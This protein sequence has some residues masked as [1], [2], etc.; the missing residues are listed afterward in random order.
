MLRR[1]IIAG[2]I[3][4]VAAIPVV[5]GAQTKVGGDV[6]SFLELSVAQPN[7]FAS[8]PAHSGS[9]DYSLSINAQVTATDSPIQMT[10]SDGSSDSGAQHGHLVSGK[11][12]LPVA[13]QVTVGKAA[14]KSLDTTS[15]P[16]LAQWTQPITHAAAP[17]RLRQTVASG[18][19]HSGYQ[20][21]L[22]LTVSGQG[23]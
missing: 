11:S 16:L 12:V 15:D 2:V 10:I 5:A 23:P 20:K 4:A 9:H 19:A 6:P 18:P 17:V 8:F 22:L 14:F 1:M 13:L 7:G 3:L 21:L